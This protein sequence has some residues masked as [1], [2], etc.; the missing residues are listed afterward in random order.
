MAAGL[1][2]VGQLL[3]LLAFAI[4]SRHLTFPIEH[5]ALSSNGAWFLFCLFLYPALGWLFG[6]YTLL[7]WRRV[8]FP[9]L[10]QRIALTAIFVILITAISAWIFR[11]QES[12]WFLHRRVQLQW[13]FGTA[14]WSLLIRL[15]LR[16]GNVWTDS[17][18]LLMLAGDSEA[19]IILRSWRR[20][21]QRKE[22]SRLSLNNIKLYIQNLESPCL[23]AVGTSWRKNEINL[24]LMEE[25]NTLDPRRIQ[26]VN[27]PAL[28]ERH[29]ER[30]PPVLLTD[31]WLNYDEIPWNATFGL[32]TQIKRASDICLALLLL[33][34]SSPLIAAAMAW[35][36]IDDPGPIFYKQVRTGWMGIP[37]TIIKLRTMQV[38]PDD[39][40]DS[41]TQLQDDRI[42]FPGQILRKLR[43]DEL[44]Q[45]FNV[46]TGEMSLIGPRPERPSME[47]IL[48]ANIPHYRMR[49]WMRPGLSGW[50]QVCAPYASSIE[51]SDLKLSYDLYY[52]KHFNIFL[53]IVILAR[54]IKTVLKAS[55]R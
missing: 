24:N 12:I 6:T 52:L 13:V 45:L 4:N 41:W 23:L 21:P 20:V 25:L 26:I 54:T 16:R 34:I 38:Q 10:L 22:L 19:E 27:P 31:G 47:K 2:F 53:D 50:A 42:T 43:I 30:L 35:I 51:D 8:P 44:P 49:H 46:L 18:Q 55:G 39:A 40:P 9:I 15:L 7:R 33:L 5:D 32:Q 37:F 11:A 17:H 28:F 29:Q 1:D 48:E 14:I 36:W 3:L